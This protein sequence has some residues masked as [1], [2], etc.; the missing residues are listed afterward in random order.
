MQDN[1]RLVRVVIERVA[2]VVDC[3]RFP[4]RRVTGESVVVEADVFADGHDE[5]GCVLRYRPEDETAWRET[6]MQ[7]LGND[8]WRGE[9]VVDS[10][11]RWHYRLEGWVDAFETWRRDLFKRRASGQDLAAELLVGAELAAAA[12]ARARSADRERLRQYARFLRSDQAQEARAEQALDDDLDGLMRLYPDRRRATRSR[13]LA[14]HVEV[15]RARY[16]TWYEMFPRSCAETAGR[17]GTFRDVERLLTYVEELGFDVL[18]LPPIHPIGR[19]QRKGRN[20]AAQAL[21]GEPGSPWAI[22]GPEGGHKALHPELGSLEDF[23]ALVAAARA[24]GIEVALDIAFQCAP[25]HP[26]VREHAEW[27]R[28]R[29]DG[30]VRHAENP[31]KKYEDIYPFDFDTEHAPALWEEL[32]SVFEFWIGQGVRVFRVD[33]PHTKP[34]AF[35][36][37]CLDGLQR[38]HRDVIFLSEAFTRPRV[39]YRLAKLGFSQSYTY[40][41]WRNGKSELEQYFTELTQTEVREFFRPNL[42]PNTPDILTE[43]L[44]AGGRPAFLGRYVLAATLGASCGVYGPAF[45]LMENKPRSPGSEE[46]LDSEK[47]EIRHWDRGR[48]DSLADFIALVNR[49]RRE[50]PALHSDR[51]LRFHRADSDFITVYSKVTPD[52]ANA[53]LTAV[54]LDFHHTHASLVHL[55]LPALGLD[56]DERF[57]VHDLLSGARYVWQGARNYVE[58]NPHECPAH[59]FRIRRQVRSE[60]DF[61]YFA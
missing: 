24:R 21:A 10:L 26:Y 50:N 35:W 42:W 55:D 8:R 41:A 49:I 51:S 12:A 32:K 56:G 2:P 61:D 31:P 1:E 52:R 47:Y 54:N 9:F 44:Q 30:S 53:I 45:E 17:H 7:P 27:F 25:D 4:V 36:E 22:G 48:P 33:N 13:E 29:P 46:Y 43:A 37:W 23:R 34:F 59:V 39:M 5:L 6:R 18:Y 11:G 14:V 19:T 60:R 38:Q 57:Q 40:F 58:L 15:P 16:S 20:N 3:G 28:R